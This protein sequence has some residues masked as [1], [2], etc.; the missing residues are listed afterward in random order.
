MSDFHVQG[1][2]GLIAIQ[3]LSFA[4]SLPL[5]HGSSLQDAQDAPLCMTN[6]Y[7]DYGDC[8]ACYD[9][10]QFNRKVF[11][12][13]GADRN[14]M[15]GKCLPGHNDDLHDGRLKVPDIVYKCVKNEKEDEPPADDTH[16]LVK[17]LV[18][19]GASMCTLL[20]VGMIYLCWKR[21]KKPRANDD[22][23]RKGSTAKTT[24]CIFFACCQGSATGSVATINMVPEPQPDQPLMPNGHVNGPPPPADDHPLEEPRP[25]QP[26]MDDDLENGLPQDEDED[27]NFP[28]PADHNPGIA[29]NDIGHGLPEEGGN[30][31]HPI[32]NQPILGEHGPERAASVVNLDEQR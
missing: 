16:A 24:N 28:E 9:C 4:L 13:C 30:P 26:L 20:G 7:Y 12:E 8:Y 25:D 21:A 15:C 3:T 17:Y 32:E 19:P 27:L 10:K 6:E 5:D 18:P 22:I 23:N 2:Q 31:G 29:V 11:E 14:T 1:F